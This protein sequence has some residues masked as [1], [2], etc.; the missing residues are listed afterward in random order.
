MTNKIINFFW[1]EG[2]LEKV[3]LLTIRS[4]QDKGHTCIIHTY[5]DKL[6]TDCWLRDCSD[7]MKKEDGKLYK[8]LH[9]NMRLGLFGDT[10]R[11]K[12]L[13]KYGGLWVDLDVLCLKPFDF[14]E[15]YVFRKHDLGVVMNVVKCPKESEFALEYIK[16][17]EAQDVTKNNWE[18]SFGGLINSVKKLGLEK[19]IRS[20]KE[21][22]MD[23]WQYWKPLL[24]EDI[25]PISEYC[26]HF[27]NSTKF[28]NSYKEGSFYDK[29]LKK[30]GIN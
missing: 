15:D 22:G 1:I 17:T 12:L 30:Y 23:N 29:M 4:F 10:L 8:G 9:H 6:T 14:E 13:H 3:N 16:Y 5:D 11:A 2:A 7:V 24:E 27:C 25:E 20:E 26:V 21:L 19:Y 28:D 18:G